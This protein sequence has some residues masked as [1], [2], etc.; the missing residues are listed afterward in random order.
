MPETIGF[1]IFLGVTITEFCL[2]CCLLI[3]IIDRSFNRAFKHLEEKD[4]LFQRIE[5]LEDEIGYCEK[6][7][8][9]N[10]VID[11][12]C[13]DCQEEHNARCEIKHEQK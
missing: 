2:M 1:D 5:K 4:K 13:P 7:E 8:H 11:A 9:L 6:H 10:S 12:Y 3:W